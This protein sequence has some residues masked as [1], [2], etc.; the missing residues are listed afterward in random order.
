MTRAEWALCE[1]YFGF[2]IFFSFVFVLMRGSFLKNRAP[3]WPHF[4]NE[5]KTSRSSRLSYSGWAQ[6]P[7][8][9]NQERNSGTGQPPQTH[10]T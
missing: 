1:T 9:R 5:T 6:A 8:S 4:I 3:P 10:F 2:T 7:T